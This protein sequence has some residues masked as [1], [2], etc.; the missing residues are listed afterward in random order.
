[1]SLARLG[2]TQGDSLVTETVTH[3]TSLVFVGAGLVLL[4]LALMQ[5]RLE[6][7]TIE[8]E[9]YVMLSVRALNRIVVAAILL[10]G[11]L[12]FFMILFLV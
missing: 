3:I 10:T 1:M 9:D 11:F 5:H 4:F 2:C 12:G 7:K 8:Q 6:I